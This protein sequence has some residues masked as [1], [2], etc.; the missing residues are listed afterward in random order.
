MIPAPLAGNRTRS[1]RVLSAIA[2]A[3]FVLTGGA[4]TFL[5]PILP[6]LAARWHLSDSQAGYFLSAQFLGTIL[7]VSVSSQLLPCRGFR[8]SIGTAYLL[9]A[10]GVSGLSLPHWKAALLGTFVVGLG[11]GVV[12][13][14]TNL[15]T[16]SLN[17]HRRASALSILNFYWGLGAVA[18]PVALALARRWN[19]VPS[20]MPVL[21][22][23][24]LLSALCIALA[25]KGEPASIEG[26]A[27]SRSR[28]ISDWP[29]AAIVGGM[30]FLYVAI[31]ASVGGWIATLVQRAT[32]GTDHSWVTAPSLFWGGLLVSRGLAPAFLRGG[33]ERRVAL[34]SLIVAC[35][36]M[37]VLVFSTRWQWI[38]VAGAIV[39]CGLA[40]VFPITI[41]LLSRFRDMEKRI[42]GPMFAL[43]GLGGAV[44]PWFVGVISTWS[45]S[46]QIGLM[47]PLVATVL[48]LWLHAV[49]NR[50]KRS[51]ADQF[52]L[53]NNSPNSSL[54]DK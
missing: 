44:V 53:Q 25:P 3:A 11:L 35:S 29:F 20:F 1:P 27:A 12:I 41:A 39:G 54:T 37:L 36:G 6:T 2:S 52:E 24:L 22:G 51:A 10:A 17:P 33:R 16:S 30:F 45:G 43:A 38:I 13:P 18:A 32:T 40:A 28:A 48:L 50:Y 7:G 8:F 15:L 42:A 47:A 46:L 34:T 9:M 19:Q 21:S 23:F 31:E 4:N 14:S 26:P 5:G 49:H